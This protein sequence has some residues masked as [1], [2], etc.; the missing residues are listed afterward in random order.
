MDEFSGSYEVF[1]YWVD[2]RILKYKGYV[3]VFFIRELRVL[4]WVVRN[5]VIVGINL[6][7][8]LGIVI[9]FDSSDSFLLLI[10]LINGI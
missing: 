3:C 8:Y 10:I 2:L 7:V 9:F 4:G 6:S 1:N 5:V